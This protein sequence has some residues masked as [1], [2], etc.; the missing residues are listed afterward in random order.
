LLIEAHIPKKSYISRSDSVISFMLSGLSYFIFFTRRLDFQL[1]TF[2][3]HG[4]SLFVIIFI[5]PRAYTV[6]RII[7]N[8]YFSPNKF[9]GFLN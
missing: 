5:I 6:N 1:P 9:I 4:W 2:H 7:L 8:V 3:L